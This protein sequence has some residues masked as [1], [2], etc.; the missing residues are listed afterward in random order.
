MI[1]RC[2]DVHTHASVHNVCM[3]KAVNMCT[4]VYTYTYLCTCT[5]RCICICACICTIHLSFYMYIYIYI[6]NIHVCFGGLCHPFQ[7]PPS[8]LG[9]L[10]PPNPPPVRLSRAVPSIPKVRPSL[11]GHGLHPLP[12]P[13]VDKTSQH[14]IKN[15]VDVTDYGN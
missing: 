13:R 5:C 9:Q 11:W 6:Y 15:L 14:P 8:F 2:Y 3:Y 7:I 10:A 12:S 4:Y 1:T